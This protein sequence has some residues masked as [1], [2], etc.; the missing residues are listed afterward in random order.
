MGRAA[1][2]S[3]GNIPL[4][5]HNLW[6]VEVAWANNMV[7]VPRVHTLEIKCTAACLL[8]WL[9]AN[10]QVILYLN[11]N[12]LWCFSSKIRTYQAK[13]Y[14]QTWMEGLCLQTLKVNQPIL[15]NSNS[16]QQFLDLVL[17]RQLKYWL[18]HINR[19]VGLNKFQCKHHSLRPLEESMMLAIC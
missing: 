12:S 6:M 7:P 15:G 1:K 17:C 3:Q 11:C 13:T 9:K 10:N 2:D 18:S 16:Q 8:E 19:P 4:N 14:H 5:I